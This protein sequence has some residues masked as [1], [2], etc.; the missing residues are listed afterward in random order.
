MCLESSTLFV[1]LVDEWK[2]M[3]FAGREWAFWLG[4]GD[5]SLKTRG[6]EKGGD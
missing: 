6:K 1:G 2:R 3:S 4:A 5:Y